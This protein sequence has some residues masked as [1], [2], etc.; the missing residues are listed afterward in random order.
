MPRPKS[1]VP[2]TGVCSE[3]SR[4]IRSKAAPASAVPGSVRGVLSRGLCERCERNT[5]PSTPQ[6]STVHCAEC[7][8]PLRS[9]SVRAAD[10]PGTVRGVL[11]R[12]ICEACENGGRVAAS[13]GELKRCQKCCQMT[14]PPGARK[15]DYPNTVARGTS[16]ICQSCWETER[17]GLPEWERQARALEVPELSAWEKLSA[18][19]LIIRSGGDT[20]ILEALGLQGII[21]S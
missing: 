16:K 12:G 19:R 3:C 20:L 17:K 9:K 21:D 1:L 4:V 10:F 18:A 7:R 11:S 15:E 13:P 2:Q 8:K 14:R 6:K 5:R